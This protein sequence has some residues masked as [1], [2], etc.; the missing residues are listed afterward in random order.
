[1]EP[2]RLVAASAHLFRTAPSWVKSEKRIFSSV[3]LFYSSFESVGR[4]DMARCDP[5]SALNLLKTLW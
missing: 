3:S 2:S 1:M 5:D 4:T